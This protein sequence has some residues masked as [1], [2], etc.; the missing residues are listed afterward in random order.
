MF[1]VEALFASRSKTMFRLC[2][3]PILERHF[4]SDDATIVQEQSMSRHCCRVNI[5]TE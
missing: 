3:S 4:S 1:A 5:E 2:M